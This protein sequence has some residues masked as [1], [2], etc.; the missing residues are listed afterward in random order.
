MS[1]RELVL[2]RVRAAVAGSARAPI[3][4]G[5]PAYAE[6]ERYRYGLDRFRK[7]LETNSCTLAE[8][9]ALA[10]VPDAVAG[11]LRG[12]DLPLR[13]AVEPG[14]LAGLAWADAGIELAAQ[15]RDDEHTAVTGVRAAI[16]E[17]GQMAVDSS[18]PANRLSLLAELHVAVVKAA[19]V[20]PSLDDLGTVLGTAPPGVISLIAG[21]SRT[22]DIQQSLVMGAHGPRAVLAVLVAEG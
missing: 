9:P 13:I 17:T 11:H 10:D 18:T 7:M 8:A 16:A 5:R 14:E 21:P 20:V 19:D 12:Q 1:D 22:G 15:L 3:A 2:K 4:G 6:A